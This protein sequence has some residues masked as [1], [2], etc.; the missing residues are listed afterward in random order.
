A[1]NRRYSDILRLGLATCLGYV[2]VV[3]AMYFGSGGRALEIFRVCAAGGGSITYAM[4]APLQM[5]GSALEFDPVMSVFLVP[6]AAFAF[7]YF[8]KVPTEILPVYFFMALMATTVIFGSRGTQVNHL[9]DLHVAAV[10]MIAYTAS[11]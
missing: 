5:I 10:L 3:S 9:I 1:I 6:A 7:S 4:E 2:I 11:R 8:K